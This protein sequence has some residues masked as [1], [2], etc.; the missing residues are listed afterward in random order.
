MAADRPCLEPAAQSIW[1]ATP[2]GDSLQVGAAA[3]EPGQA[4]C[5]GA[6][7]TASQTRCPRARRGGMVAVSISRSCCRWPSRSPPGSVLRFDVALRQNAGGRNAEFGWSA[8]LDMQPL[9]NRC[10]G[11]RSGSTRAG[12]AG[13][14]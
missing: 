4:P 12:R 8:S 1:S 10:C 14:G 6:V 5:E 13:G 9:G 7:R 3:P 2:D 11:A